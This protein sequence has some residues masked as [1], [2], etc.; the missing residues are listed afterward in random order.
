MSSRRS[1]SRERERERVGSEAGSGRREDAI[2]FWPGG[3]VLTS[4][5]VSSSMVR[6]HGQALPVIILH[7]IR[8]SR[9]P[10][11]PDRRSGDGSLPIIVGNGNFLHLESRKVN[12]IRSFLH[13]P[14]PFLGAFSNWLLREVKVTV[15][16]TRPAGHWECAVTRRSRL[17]SIVKIVGMLILEYDQ[18][19]GPLC[20]QLAPESHFFWCLYLCLLSISEISSDD[21]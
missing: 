14:L 12:Q 2:S 10:P 3:T 21:S 17:Q 18:I 4:S 13:Y 1:D 5:P 15:S 9:F 7:Q 11:T 16:Q 19:T 20:C 6:S 8:L